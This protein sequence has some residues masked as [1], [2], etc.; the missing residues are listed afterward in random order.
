MMRTSTKA[1][2]ADFKN[3]K[4]GG[5]MRMDIK[6]WSTKDYLQIWKMRETKGLG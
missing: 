3:W 5:D 6:R 4:K 1:V 2:A